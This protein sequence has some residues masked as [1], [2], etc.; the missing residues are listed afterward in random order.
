VSLSLLKNVGIGLLHF[1]VATV[2]VSVGSAFVFSFLKPVLHVF[3]LGRSANSDAVLWCRFFPF[4]ASVA[5]ACSWHLARRGGGVGA[6]RI[7]RLIW[8]VPSV[9]LLFLIAVWRDQSSL[10]ESRW[11]HFL[12]SRSAQA[13]RIQIV[14]TLPLIT[15]L[16]YALGNYCGAGNSSKN[17]AGP[18]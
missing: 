6:A 17:L 13:L 1:V 9:W 14:S 7:V 15:T 16:A 18:N 2:A 10:G 4:Q 11:Q 3:M 8:I 5:F 12:W